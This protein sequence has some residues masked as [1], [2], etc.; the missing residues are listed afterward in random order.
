[1]TPLLRTALYAL[2]VATSIPTLVAAQDSSSAALSRRIEHLER[3]NA[4]LERRVRLL[5]SLITTQGPQIPRAS[6]SSGSQ[7]LSNWR[8]LRR[9]MSMDEVR[10]V[11]GEPERVE[12]GAVTVWRWGNANVY[13]L[14]DKL[15]GW[16]EPSR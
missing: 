5:E 3:A 6:T 15:E 14:D 10:A 13:F 2:V 9:G 11:L 16:S 8:R 1:M 12:A 7:D 4:E